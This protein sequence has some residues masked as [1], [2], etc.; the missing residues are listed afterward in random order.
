MLLDPSRYKEVLAITFTNDAKNEMKSRILSDLTSIAEDEDSS[1]R[2]VILGDFERE[3]IENIKDV[4]TSRAQTVLAHLLHDYTRFHVSTIDHF[5]AQLIRHLAREL[6]LNLGYEL[7]IDVETALNES[8]K[9]LFSTANDELLS[10]LKDFALAQIEDDKGWNIQKSIATLGKK[11]FQESY[12]DIRD[13]LDSGSLHLSK[14][15][16]DQRAIISRSR[17]SLNRLGR[18]GMDALKNNNVEP[19]DLKGKA[20]GQIAIVSKLAGGEHDF[21]K[22]PSATFLNSTEVIDWYISKSEKINQ[23]EAAWESGLGEAQQQIAEFYEGISYQQYIEADAI[24]K[25]IHSY[26]VLAALS[27]QVQEYRNKH[28]LLLI[29]D[30]AMILTKVIEEQEMPFIYEKIGSKFKYVLIDEFQDTSTHQWNSLLPFLKNAI[31]QGGQLII[32]GDVKQAIY[33]WRGG[34]INLLLNQVE[35]DLKIGEHSILKLDTNYRSGKSI[36]AFNNSFFS[37]APK[38]VADSLE[39]TG[40]L[41][42]FEK[43]YRDVHQHAH[44]QAEGYVHIQFYGKEE[45][46]SWQDQA[47]HNTLQWIERCIIDGYNYSDILILTRKNSEARDIAHH[48]ISADIPTIS[49]EALTVDSSQ[50]VKL[51]L[52]A[53]KYLQNQDDRVA[54]AEFNYF[55]KGNSQE[56]LANLAEPSASLKTLLNFNNKPFYELVEE[57]IIVLKLNLHPDIYI[58]RFLDICLG[59]AQKGNYT[60]GE[61][62]DWWVSMKE[63]NNSS[64]LSI[65]LPA[66]NNAVR[67]MT[68]HKAKGLEKPIVIVPYADSPLP[69]KPNSIFWANPLPENYEEWGSLPL[70]FTRLLAETSFES[71]YQQELFKQSLESLNLLYVAFTRA[72]NRLI[73]FANNDSKSGNTGHLIKKTISHPDFNFGGDFDEP[74]GLFTIGEIEKAV[75]S[76]TSTSSN[77]LEQDSPVTSLLPD[78]IT[79]DDRPSKLFMAYKNERTEKIKEGIL[80]HLALS[81]LR[82]TSEIELVVKQIELEQSLDKPTIVRLSQKLHELFEALPLVA[83]WFNGSWQVIN[84]RKIY[85]DGRIY[86]PDR[87]MIKDNQAMVIDYK[88]EKQDKKHHRQV[89]EYALLLTKM[90][91]EIVGKYLIYIDET[92]L[93]EV[94]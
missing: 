70:A 7:D 2:T 53:L 15:I 88:R 78:K 21:K 59:Q 1:M 72:K 14:F 83:G 11:L 32:V 47:I 75:E 45:A 55:S 18:Q 31:D 34:D 49:D 50:Q 16:K 3:N 52:S 30:T 64:E 8:V 17:N 56:N 40:Y 20:G 92:L 9:T 71:N 24:L 62:L 46:N 89:N 13:Q 77:V 58:Q 80:L 79:L 60:L 66:N 28:N 63:R 29:S 61:F 35:R 76:D 57:L 86:I 38:N 69:P 22:K 68:V 12:L 81:R 41:D 73:I 26:G 82:H 23:I 90:G 51:L 65:G 94:E 10:W 4:M 84:E 19:I 48:L 27:R 42:E 44:K 87:I 6:K 39:L 43:A 54:I 91:F 74:Q 33:G 67:V 93:I 25:Y 36:V 37:I 85:Q 5:F